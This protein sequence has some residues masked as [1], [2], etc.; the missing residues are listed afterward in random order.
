MEALLGI[1]ITL[2]LALLGWFIYHSSQCTA[3]HERV[4]SLEADVKSIKAEVG[5]HESGLRGSVHDLRNQISPMYLDWQ[6][7]QRQ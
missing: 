3:F 5:D 6:R 1:V 2:Q 4:A 7:R